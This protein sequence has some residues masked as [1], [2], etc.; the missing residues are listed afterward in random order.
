MKGIS[1]PRKPRINCNRKAITNA[2]TMSDMIARAL[3]D[4]I[5][6]KSSLYRMVY[7]DSNSNIGR[8]T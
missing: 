7:A 8:K 4:R 1:N 5:F 6:L 3:M 2:D